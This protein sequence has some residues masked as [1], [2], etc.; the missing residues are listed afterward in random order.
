MP[1]ALRR[2]EHGLHR[3]LRRGEVGREAALVPDRGRETALVEQ[4]GEVVEDL[5]PHAQALRERLRPGRDHHELLQ[6]ERVARVRTPV[7]HVQ[8]RHRQDVRAGP[9]D[10]AVQRHARTRRRGPRGRQRAAEHSVRSEPRLVFRPVQLEQDGIHG[11]L[12]V[13]VDAQQCGAELSAH[14]GDRFRDALAEPRLA[15]VPQ[16]ERLVHAGRSARRHCGP[17]DRSPLQLDLHLDGRVSPRVEDLPCTDGCDGGY[18]VSS[19][20]ARSY[21][22]S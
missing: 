14:V 8:H 3:R 20:L 22:R 5:D 11:A 12:V 6:L 9:A 4:L 18:R 16:L 21:Q 13:G 19:S 15:A 2:L 10:P 1:C 7:D 17:A